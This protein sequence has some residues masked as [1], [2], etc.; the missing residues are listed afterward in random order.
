MLRAFPRRAG[1][2]P[3]QARCRLV[4][5]TWPGRPTFQTTNAFALR[6]SAHGVGCAHPAARLPDCTH[7]FAM[8]FKNLAVLCMRPGWAT[9]S[10]GKPCRTSMV[11]AAFVVGLNTL[12]G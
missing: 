7:G 5:R 9:L 8:L 12:P 11:T 4:L 10:F 2:V 3:L 1:V 6:A